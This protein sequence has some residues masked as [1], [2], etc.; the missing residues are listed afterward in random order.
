MVESAFSV[1]MDEDTR[2]SE[3]VGVFRV[4]PGKK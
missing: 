2:E 4:I 1:I 3:I